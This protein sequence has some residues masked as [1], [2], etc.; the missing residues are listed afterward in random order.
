MGEQPF[1]VIKYQ[2]ALKFLFKWKCQWPS[3]EIRISPHAPLFHFTR[4]Q[5][6]LEVTPCR[7]ISLCMQSAREETVP[8]VF[9]T[10]VISCETNHLSKPGHWRKAA[11][12]AGC[13]SLGSWARAHALTALVINSGSKNYWCHHQSLRIWRW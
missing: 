5:T 11:F 1:T 9:L 13:V 6:S 12:A 2:K 7:V 3:F 4:V 8:R 10:G